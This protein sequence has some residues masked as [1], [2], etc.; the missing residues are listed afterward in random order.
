[1][2]FTNQLKRY[3]RCVVQKLRPIARPYTFYLKTMRI[4]SK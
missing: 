3:S 2:Q 4:L 1:M